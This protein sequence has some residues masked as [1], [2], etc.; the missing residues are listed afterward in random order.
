M[1]HPFIPRCHACDDPP[2]SSPST[3]TTS[4]SLDN[5]WYTDGWSEWC[6]LF[7]AIRFVILDL[8]ESKPR[9]ACI[10]FLLRQGARR[11]NLSTIHSPCIQKPRVDRE[12]KKAV[13]REL[14]GHVFAPHAEYHMPTQ[15]R[16]RQTPVSTP[17]ALT[18]PSLSTQHPFRAGK[19]H[20]RS[21]YTGIAD[22]QR[23]YNFCRL[24]TQPCSC[25]HSMPVLSSHL[26]K[27]MCTSHREKKPLGLSDRRNMP[28]DFPKMKRATSNKQTKSKIKQMGFL[29]S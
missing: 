29:T 24:P 12:R 27:F 25:W 15:G 2:Y 18:S 20:T 23:V 28:I 13:P 9:I 14:H 16:H 8:L 11:R 22:A 26:E 10:F 19:K 5:T 21:Y 1:I 6:F 3:Q 17:S 7:S 4:S